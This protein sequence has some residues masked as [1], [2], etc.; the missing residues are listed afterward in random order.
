MDYLQTIVSLI[1]SLGFPIVM[2]LLLWQYIK[3]EQTKTREV[4]TELRETITTLT[5][6][7]RERGKA[8]DDKG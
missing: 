5:Q 1:G 7:V 8:D 3:E 4:L 6:Y 2:T